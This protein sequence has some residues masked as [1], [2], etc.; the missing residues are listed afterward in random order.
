MSGSVSS[1]YGL[2]WSTPFSVNSPPAKTAVFPF[3]AAYNGVADFVY[4]GTTGAG[5]D[6][7]TAVWY[8]YMAQTADGG[9][10]FTQGV[11][12][13]HAIRVGTLA[14]SLFADLFEVAINP[15]NG[16]AGIAYTDV[17]LTT[18]VSGD[19]QPQTVLARQQ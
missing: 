9:S 14:R 8:P 1:D 2:S 5:Q 13:D 18:T 15:Q 4:Y 19:P 12:S 11:V 17:T 3:I 6:D 10:T 16:L 7:P